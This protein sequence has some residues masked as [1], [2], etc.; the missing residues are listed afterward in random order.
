MERIEMVA[1]TN[2]GRRF[3]FHGYPVTIEEIKEY[4]EDPHCKPFAIEQQDY[5]AADSFETAAD[6]STVMLE[7]I[8][9]GRYKAQYYVKWDGRW[10]KTSEGGWLEFETDDTVWPDALEERRLQALDAVAN[11]MAWTHTCGLTGMD[12][13]TGEHTYETH[14]RMTGKTASDWMSIDYEPA[15][16]TLS[17]S[18]DKDSDDACC[19]ATE[20]MRTHDPLWSALTVNGEVIWK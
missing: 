9:D 13:K 16:C 3:K 20:I 14:V 17:L 5:T 19:A 10:F 15:S 7:F 11:A 8:E 1:T 4:A 12:V 18:Y 6:G 2:A